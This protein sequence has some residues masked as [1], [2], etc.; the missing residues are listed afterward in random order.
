MKVVIEFHRVRAYDDAL[1][2]IGRVSCDVIDAEAA[3][4]LAASLAISLAMPQE[5]DIVTISDDRRNEFYRANVGFDRG[6]RADDDAIAIGV[7]ENEGGAVAYTS[8]A[9]PAWLRSAD[10]H[11]QYQ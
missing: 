3:I 9:R 6:V 7:W 8:V 11:S 2:K 1:A 10:S 5:P 4:G